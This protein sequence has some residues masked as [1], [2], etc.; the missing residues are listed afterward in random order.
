[1]NVSL[2][3]YTTRSQH[4]ANVFNVHQI[5]TYMRHTIVT[6]LSIQD[7]CKNQE[8][9]IDTNVLFNMKLWLIY[10]SEGYKYSS[11]FAI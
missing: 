9:G 4:K 10:Y 1:M 3:L 6:V 2:N 5:A 7:T 8:D 11:Y